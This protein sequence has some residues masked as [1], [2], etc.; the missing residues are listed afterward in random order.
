MSS[1]P[2]GTHPNIGAL[3]GG[4]GVPISDVDHKELNVALLNLRNAHVTLSILNNDHV[5]CHYLFK[6]HVACH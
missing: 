5:P 1:A 6:S 4:G 2:P 3:D